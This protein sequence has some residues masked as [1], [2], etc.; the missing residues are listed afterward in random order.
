MPGEISFTESRPLKT[1]PQQSLKKPSFKMIP[2]NNL[3]SAEDDLLVRVGGQRMIS[4]QST[5][6][7]F[8]TIS[9]DKITANKDCGKFERC[10]GCKFRDL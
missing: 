5:K 9:N 2:E 6:E 10:A 4:S 8:A 3:E 7:A 1:Q